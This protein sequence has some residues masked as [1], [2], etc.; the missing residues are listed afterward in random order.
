MGLAR[1]S[2]NSKRPFLHGEVSIAVSRQIVGAHVLTALLDIDLGQLVQELDSTAS[3]IVTN[4]RDSLVLRKE[5]AQKTK[6]YKKLDDTGK[7]SETK[8][9]LKG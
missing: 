8:G 2:I 5:L 4:Q 9:L 3:A 1:M 6:D 7:L